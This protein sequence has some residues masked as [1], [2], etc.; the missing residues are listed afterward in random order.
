MQH[1]IDIKI[2]FFLGTFL[3]DCSFGTGNIENRSHPQGSSFN[4]FYRGDPSEAKAS[5][6]RDKHTFV[7]SDSARQSVCCNLYSFRPRQIRH[8]L[9]KHLWIECLI[10]EKI[11]IHGHPMTEM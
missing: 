8:A 11:K 6:K 9:S 10:R 7:S 5:E 2:I 4:P 1:G 3:N